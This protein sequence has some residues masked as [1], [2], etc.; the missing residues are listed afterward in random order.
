VREDLQIRLADATDLRTTLAQMAAIARHD[1]RARV[2]ELAGLEVTVIHGTE[3][4]LVP[5]D[6]GRELAAAIPG[7]R[8]VMIPACGH[9]LTTDA[10][11]EAAA[12]VRGHLERCAAPSSRVA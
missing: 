3:D 9:M 1:T 12:A 8:L 7:A 2:H 11:P 10:E 5:S 6:R 4:A